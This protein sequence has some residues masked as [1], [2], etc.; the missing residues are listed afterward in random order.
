[1][2]TRRKLASDEHRRQWCQECKPTS[3]PTQHHNMASFLQS[4]ILASRSETQSMVD[5]LCETVHCLLRPNEA[6]RSSGLQRGQQM[7]WGGAQDRQWSLTSRPRNLPFGF[8]SVNPSNG[9]FE[10]LS[11]DEA[12]LPRSKW[13]YL[14]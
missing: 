14:E 3:W 9:G 12:K 10:L 5:V 13:S 6:A 4:V 2:L 1:M 7:A 8:A 11:R